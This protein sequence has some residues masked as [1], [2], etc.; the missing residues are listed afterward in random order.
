MDAAD[1]AK[2][3]EGRIVRVGVT[4]LNDRNFKLRPA[5]IIVPPESDDPNAPMRV[6]CGSRD[7]PEA[8]NFPFALRVTGSPPPHTPKSGLP[9]NTWFY[10]AWIRTVKARDVEHLFKFMPSYQ[11]VELRG[12]IDAAKK[13]VP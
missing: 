8:A 1:Y 3:T 9:A 7:A 12:M 10:A 6:V 11:V 2:L 13:K 5:V 4:D